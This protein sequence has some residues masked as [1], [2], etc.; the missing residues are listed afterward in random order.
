MASKKKKVPDEAIQIIRIRK[1]ATKKEIMAAARR[2]FTA[3]DLAKFF[4]V[5]EKTVPM[6]QVLAR[7]ET[8]HQ[9]EMRKQSKRSNG[10]L[11]AR[12]AATPRVESK[13]QP[14]KPKAGRFLRTEAGDRI[15]IV[16]VR[17]GATRKEIQAAARR[18]F[19]ADDL[20]LYGEIEE[21]SPFEQI[22]AR[23]EA[24]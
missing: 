20:A 5:D 3:D 18:A 6:E 13:R 8:I 2:A 14:R 24:I 11:A 23:C 16:K 21:G 22:V 7:L 15:S 19:S 10:K 4:Q 17:K 12:A 9:E 1:G